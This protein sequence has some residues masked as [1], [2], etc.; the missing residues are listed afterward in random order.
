LEAIGASPTAE[1]RYTVPVIKDP[2][3]GAIV[4]DSLAIAEYLDKTYPEN[5][6]IP[7]SAKVLMAGFEPMYCSTAYGKAVKYILTR[8]L[9]IQN[10]SSRE[11][12]ISTRLAM[13]GASSW[14][15]VEENP[16][17]QWEDWKEGL[18]VRGHG[19]GLQDDVVECH[20][21]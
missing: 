14:E 1:N 5:P 12:F 3:T 4:S 20:L 21:G 17:Q 11:Y 8:T 10:D 2:N 9:A 19:G 15:E 13:L 18:L 7:R 6:I 16:E